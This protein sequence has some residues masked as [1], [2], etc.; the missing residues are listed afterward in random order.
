MSG[1]YPGAFEKGKMVS[2]LEQIK[3]SIAFH[4]GTRQE[5]DQV[6]TNGGRVFAITALGK[7]IPEAREKVYAAAGNLTY[8][9]KYFRGDVGLDLLKP[10]SE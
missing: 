8:D 1:G 4:S 6:L 3:E 7:N 5:G 2:G 9:K 10:I